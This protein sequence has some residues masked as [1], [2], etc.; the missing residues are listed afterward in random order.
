M[1]TDKKILA[2]LQSK[3]RQEQVSDAL[4]SAILSGALPPGTKL[5]ETKL[6]A[7]LNVSRGPLR[8]AMKGLIQTNLLANKPFSGTY[9][10]KPDYIY[11]ANCY[12]VRR[13]LEKLAFELIWMHRDDAFGEA[14]NQRFAQLQEVIEGG[15]PVDQ[16][17]GEMEFHGLAYELSGNDLLLETWRNLAD[18]IRLSFLIHQHSLRPIGEY[19]NSHDDFMKCALGDDLDA[20]KAQIDIH[21][22]KGLK[23]AKKFF[24]PVDALQSAEVR[25]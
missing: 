12:A 20:M 21:L 19:Y 14:L 18:R 17:H 9:V 1:S 4:R 7:Q 6:A 23:T 10:S 2:P 16:I 3:T 11:V 15:S 25:V 22:D 8:E 24:D 5:N 13:P